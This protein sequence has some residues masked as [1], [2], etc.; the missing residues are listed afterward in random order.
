MTCCTVAMSS[1][2][3]M[4]QPSS[5]PTAESAPW[6]AGKMDRGQAEHFLMEVRTNHTSGLTHRAG[7]VNG[8]YCNI[9]DNNL[10]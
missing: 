3:Y 5:T 8:Y 1:A 9:L 6:F 7:R 4:L 2:S 10:Q